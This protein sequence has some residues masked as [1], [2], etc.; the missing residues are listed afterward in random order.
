[1]NFTAVRITFGLVVLAALAVADLLE[2]GRQATR[3]REYLFLAFCTAI[4]TVYGMVNDQVTSRISWEYFYYGKNL[5]PILGAQTPP[6]AMKLSLQA[7]RIGASAT[8]WAGLIFGAAMLIA[9]NPG[10]IGRQ[11]SFFSL[12]KRLPVVVGI[13]VIFAVIFGFAGAHYYLN[14]ISPD[15]PALVATDFWRP[16]RFMAVYGIHLGGYVG[17]V[18]GAIY[19]ITSIVRERRSQ[20]P[21]T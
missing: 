21:L 12:A 5:A 7:I 20:L 2:K 19:A 4:A 11:L 15:F 9:N 16:H 1:M 3:W 14:W 18:V 8:W 17:G 13:T 6:D 10:R